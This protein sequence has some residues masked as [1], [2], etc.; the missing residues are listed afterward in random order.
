MNSINDLIIRKKFGH[1]WVLVF[2]HS[3]ANNL[4]FND[5][6]VMS[7]NAKDRYSILGTLNNNHRIR[8]KFEF[9]LEYSPTEYNWWRQTN[10]PN[11]EPYKTCTQTRT[12]ISSCPVDGFECIDCKQNYSYWGGLGKSHSDPNTAYSYFDGS[13]GVSS[14]FFAIGSRKRWTST[15]DIPGPKDSVK[16]VSLWMRSDKINAMKTCR[17]K[18]SS[19]INT[20]LF[21]V[22]LTLNK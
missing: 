15:T 4:Y 17:S 11:N 5:C 13:I 8:N 20:V 16:H 18:K 3:A 22:I 2:Y 9:L 1:T 6:D 14:W 7:C 10:S 12:D 19:F 21:F